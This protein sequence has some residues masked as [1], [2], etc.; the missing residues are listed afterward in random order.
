MKR[1]NLSSIDF[2]S[3]IERSHERCKIFGIDKGMERPQNILTGK[4]LQ[5]ILD[6][7]DDLIKIALPFMKLLYKFF[8]GS[9]FIIDI[10]DKNG[11]ILS[12]VGDDDVIALATDMGMT[13]GTDMSE[14]SCGTNSIGT[15]L[16]EKCPFQLAQNQHFIDIYHLWTCSSSPIRDTE[17]TIIG[18]LNLTGIYNLVHPHT[19]GL[20]FAAVESIE[21]EL[22][23]RRSKE[24]LSQMHQYNN[25]IVNSIDFGI[26]SIDS[27]GYV[28]S[29]NNKCL[30]IFSLSENKIIGKKA[31]GIIGN[32]KEI[33]SSIE[34][35]D[36][37][38]NIEFVYLNGNRKKRF[39]LNAYPIK[40]SLGKISGM[41]M[42][43]KDIENVY[44]LVNKYSGKNAYYTFDDI[45]GKSPQIKEVIDYSKTIANT[46][47]TVLIQGESGTGK[48]VLAQS[49][50]N[51][52][53]RKNGAFI[54]INCGGIP[55]NLIE[56]ELFG[57]EDGAFTGSKK[58]G[59]PG[60]FEL[61]NNGTIFLDEIGE[62]PIDMQVSLL[63]VLQEKCITRVGGTRRIPIDVRVMAA[64]NKNLI[65]EIKKENFRQDLYYRLSVIPVYLPP[66][67]QRRDDIK[68]LIDHFL[69]K[70]SQRLGIQSPSISPGDY[71][72]LIS[73]NWPGNV[74]ELENRIE[75]IVVN[76]RLPMDFYRLCCD[77]KKPVQTGEKYEYTMCS[78][79]DWEKIAIIQC[80]QN[81]GGN[82]SKTARVLKID[83]STLY[84]KLEKYSIS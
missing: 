35:D 39:N 17:G 54:A 56:S 80:L 71:E 51:S 52:S 65:D 37:Y 58:G 41:V 76:G 8:K 49:I 1:D 2:K 32:W 21:N 48:E 5:D 11:Y 19:L 7:N 84:K 66:L 3:I 38:S 29:A 45:V 16:H 20:V 34:K 53:S 68:L 81:C 46:P 24:E 82:I 47:S 22:R 55:K 57:Y 6:K 33:F 4:K 78:L 10:A 77:E 72:L 59:M 31:D 23:I 70:K 73:Y 13:V 9:G 18:C 44:K 75:N 28:Q 36:T 61:A 69:E 50:H 15:G 63:R 64:T 26:L 30:E 83:R 12:I 79:S 40:N 74:R 27:K 43:L 60:K 42:M 67:R 14:K 62:M 25:T